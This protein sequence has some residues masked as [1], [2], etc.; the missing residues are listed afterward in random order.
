MHAASL[1]P[2]FS[3]GAGNVISRKANGNPPHP[4]ARTPRHDRLQD[5]GCRARKRLSIVEPVQFDV[6][7]A[8]RHE[9]REMARTG[10]NPE[11]VPKISPSHTRPPNDRG[12]SCDGL[13]G[14]ST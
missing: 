14:K 10:S 8:L 4:R 6:Q 2:D 11:S 13:S 5:R 9:P 1:E 12:S 3:R 7:A